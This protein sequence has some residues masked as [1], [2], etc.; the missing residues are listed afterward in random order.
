MI[1]STASHYLALKNDENGIEDFKRM[2]ENIWEMF[3][4]SVCDMEIDKPSLIEW[5]INVQ[6]TIRCVSIRNNVITSFET[7]NL[8]FKSLKV[9]QYFCLTE[10][11]NSC[12][13]I[14]ITEPIAYRSVSIDHCCLTLPAILNGTNS[15]ILSSGSEL[16]PTDINTVLKEWQTGTKLQN[17][18]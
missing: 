1:R 18:E 4:S 11:R 12:P 6:P 13:K 5:I 16:L 2:V 15:I 17:L 9:T 7:L 8:L 14:V 3:P 10:N